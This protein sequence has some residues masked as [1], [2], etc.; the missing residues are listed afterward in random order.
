MPQKCNNIF[1][2]FILST[3]INTNAADVFQSELCVTPLFMFNCQIMV[4]ITSITETL[5]ALNCFIH[6]SIT[7]TS[8]KYLCVSRQLIHLQ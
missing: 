2:K 4:H 5:Q 1:H 8:V 7:N 6:F 3:N